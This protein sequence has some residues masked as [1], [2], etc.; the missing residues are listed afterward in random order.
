MSTILVL[1]ARSATIKYRLDPAE[2]VLGSASLKRIG[3]D[4]ARVLLRK[5]ELRQSMRDERRH[6]RPH[7]HGVDAPRRRRLD[8][9]VLISPRSGRVRAV[10]LG[11]TVAPT[12]K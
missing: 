10:P 6:H 11:A 12:T 5:A 8:R 1:N 2:R 9:A 4:V 3:E 7:A